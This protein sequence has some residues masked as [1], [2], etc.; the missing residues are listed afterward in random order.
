MQAGNFPG[1]ILDFDLGS[2]ENTK[3]RYGQIA[4]Q[5]V[6]GRFDGE[7]I[8]MTKALTEKTAEQFREALV[9]CG[10]NCRGVPTP[11][12]LTRIVS[13]AVQPT[14]FTV[15]DQKTGKKVQKRGLEVAFVRP[16][17]QVQNP[18]DN[19]ARSQFFADLLAWSG[20]PPP[21]E[22]TDDGEEY[23]PNTGEVFGSDA[24]AG[25]FEEEASPS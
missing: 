8:R 14:E 6:G 18:L 12:T 21:T 9:A 4:F 25:D 5:L 11:A 7:T 13:L 23:D 20:G 17:V 1:R 2:N 16:L 10:W 24:G 3:N 15:I 19:E 22:E